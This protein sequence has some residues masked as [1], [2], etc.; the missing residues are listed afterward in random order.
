MTERTK[1]IHYHEYE[2]VSKLPSRL[3]TLLGHASD[4]C[5]HA[6]AP[7]S[8]FRVGAAVECKDGKI[9]LGSNQENAAYPSGLCAERVA[10]FSAMSNNPAA[11]IETIAITVKTSNNSA[12][13]PVAPCGACRQ[14]IA[15]YEHK[16]D[17]EIELL[18]TGE[19]GK[20]IVVKGISSLLPFT[21]TS[22]NLPDF[23]K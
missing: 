14:V 22:D 11:I 20:I 1:A 7:Y 9:V 4:A 13:D 23:K 6:H 5:N 16:Q 12:L 10:V 19:S 21:F 8:G 3:Q 18:F 2:H 15:E 17:K